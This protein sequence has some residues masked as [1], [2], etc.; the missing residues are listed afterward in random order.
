M[1]DFAPMFKRRSRT[2]RTAS[3]QAPSNPHDFDMRALPILS[4]GQLLTHVGHDPKLSDLFRLVG[5]GERHFDLLFRRPL[6]RF[7]EAVQLAPASEN[8]HHCGP[9]GLLQHTLEVIQLALKLRQGYQLPIGGS[10]DVMA[11]EEHHW[12]Y[13]IFVACLFHDIGKV[14]SRIQLR[15]NM[16]DGRKRPWTPHDKPITQTG[17]DSYQIQF[18]ECPY[19]AHQRLSVTLYASLLPSAGRAWLTQH[20]EVM[21]QTLASIWGDGY[22]S[23]V[24]GEIVTR[25]DRESTARNTDTMHADRRMAGAKESLGDR[26]MQRL[27]QLLSEGEIKINKSGAMGFVAGETTYFVCRPLAEKLIDS[28]KDTGAEGIP[29]DPVRIYDVLQEHGFALA[30]GDGKAIRKV[31]VEGRGFS[32][33]LTCLKFKTRR[34]WVPVRL[35][36]SFEGNITEVGAEDERPSVS[37]EQ[38]PETSSKAGA[39]CEPVGGRGPD[40]TAV[41]AASH[42]PEPVSQAQSQDKEPENGARRPR[43][44]EPERQSPEPVQPRAA[45]AGPAQEAETDDAVEEET[46]TASAPEPETPVHEARKPD[47]AEQAA[48]PETAPETEALPEPEVAQLTWED[49]VGTAFWHWIQ[50]GIRQKSLPA[51]NVRAQI[52]F[53]EEGIFLV[54]PRI[55]KAYCEKAGLGKD[56]FN[57]LQKRF[58]RLKLHTKTPRTHFNVHPY[59]VDTGNRTARL[60]G[61]LVPYSKVF[62]PDEELPQFNKYLR[63]LD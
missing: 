32:H 35:P 53:V 11:R 43:K 63:P 55:F 49:E 56:G 23:G 37:T 20:S 15:L 39:A 29:S 34:L 60:N 7:A 52:H 45:A 50:E 59:V 28:L 3:S 25:A 26:L 58:A 19:K 8:N 10:P 14:L 18:Q 6:H 4:A 22:E 17:A 57:R 1:I 62:G 31:R 16:P 30:Y 54:T 48:E 21:A 47:E 27:R 61:Y 51:N 33:T 13:G 24:I 46:G 42:K 44:S 40:S 38:E 12:T 41:K 5:V 2:R 9:G 36:Q